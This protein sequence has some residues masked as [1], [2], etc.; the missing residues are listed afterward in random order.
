MPTPAPSSSPATSRPRSRAGSA[1]TA[2]AFRSPFE[3]P[4]EERVS[5]PKVRGLVVIPLLAVLHFLIQLK[6]LLQKYNSR[7][8]NFAANS[9]FR[10]AERSAPGR[11]TKF[12]F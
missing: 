7:A 6:S 8:N 9:A 1:A 11:A 3:A 12:A 2:R 10:L 5:A 4:H